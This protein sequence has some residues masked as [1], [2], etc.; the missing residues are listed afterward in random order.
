MDKVKEAFE[1]VREDIEFLNQEIS[2]L[3]ENL[4]EIKN[5]IDELIEEIHKNQSLII[6]THPTHIPTH[7]TH[8]PTHP[9]HNLPLNDLKEQNMP[10][11]T[12]NQGVPT[13]KQTN[14]QTDKQTDQHMGKEG[15]LPKDHIE[16]ASEILDS[17]DNLKKEVRLKFK[18]L[19]E[20]EWLIFSTLYQLE[21]EA[22]NVD[23][24]LLSKRL[25]LTES[26]IR[27]YIGRL[28]KKG[29][30]IDKKKINNKNI[31]LFISKN[32]RNIASL[33]T[34]LHLRDL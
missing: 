25:N 29:I 33:Q 9:T 34:I 23:Y 22:G 27:D 5:L 3:H 30:P 26:S 15:F 24:R 13:D 21:E 7:P 11:S 6:P 1:K 28:I 32:L 10:F 4:F 19:T 14:R 12:G 20:Q 2:N 8:I 18:R 16:K 31:H 17:L